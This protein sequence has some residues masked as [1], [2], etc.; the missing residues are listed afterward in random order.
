MVGDMMSD[1]LRF[2]YDR[3]APLDVQTT[4]SGK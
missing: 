4:R 1:P 3:D 2:D